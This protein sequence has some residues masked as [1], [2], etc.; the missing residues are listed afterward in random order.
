[1][2]RLSKGLRVCPYI[3]EPGS[4]LLL[5][6]TLCKYLFM[7]KVNLLL[8]I[9][10]CIAS[11]SF[12][13]ALQSCTFN[14]TWDTDWGKL[15]ISG[16]MNN[17]TGKYFFNNDN[18]VSGTISGVA[19][20]ASGKWPATEIFLT[21]TWS[22]TNTSGTFSLRRSCDSKRFSG[23]WKNNNAKESGTWS[24]KLRE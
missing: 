5:L 22:Q 16:P 24:G 14:G 8:A 15:V 18:K 23:T 7:K 10:L 21:G 17:V 1:M 4:F 2:A 19:K 9:A 11:T 20:E 3:I 12:R 6:L 13:P